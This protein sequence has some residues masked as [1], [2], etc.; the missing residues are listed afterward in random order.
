[1]GHSTGKQALMGRLVSFRAAAR[2]L[3]CDYQT[4]KFWAD[5]GFLP[6]LPTPK[7]WRLIPRDVVERLAKGEIALTASDMEA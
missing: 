4:V 3:G 7:G 5:Q 2:Y 6:T 1:M